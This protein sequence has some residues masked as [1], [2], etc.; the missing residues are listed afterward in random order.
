MEWRGER[1][2]IGH[3][4]VRIAGVVLEALD[5]HPLQAQDLYPVQDPG[6]AQA[7][8]E[9]GNGGGGQDEVLQ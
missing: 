7:A 2:A 9:E 4:T 5:R 8:A 3:S 6:V 1:A